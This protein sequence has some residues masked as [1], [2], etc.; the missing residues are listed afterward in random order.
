[1]A[2]ADHE[3]YAFGPLQFGQIEH[4]SRPPSSRT[5]SH[6]LELLEPQHRISRVVLSAGRAFAT[7]PF[8]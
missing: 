5:V 7:F 1:M 6:C 3:A 8:H 2:V 4:Y